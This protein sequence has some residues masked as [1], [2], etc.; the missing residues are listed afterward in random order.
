MFIVGVNAVQSS[1]NEGQLNASSV[2]PNLQCSRF[3]HELKCISNQHSPHTSTLEE[4]CAIV[5]VSTN[6][7]FQVIQKNFSKKKKK[8]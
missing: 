4:H 3:K 6:C 5:A 7:M 1:E 2:M 8:I